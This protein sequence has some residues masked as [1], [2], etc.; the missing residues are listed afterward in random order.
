MPWL[1]MARWMRR[2]REVEAET[3]AYLGAKRTGISPRSESYLEAY[4]GAFDKLDLH[5]ILEAAGIV[6]KL[7]GLPFP[8]QQTFKP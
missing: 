1:R 4:Q 3:V 7:L 5:R 8:E 6:E 2:R